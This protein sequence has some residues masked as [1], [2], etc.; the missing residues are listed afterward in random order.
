M[1]NF[2]LI[3]NAKKIVY[4]LSH[5]VYMATKIKII[6]SATFAIKLL[7]TIQGFCLKFKNITLKEIF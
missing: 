4:L 6:L 1:Q 3:I 7:N 5:R 2:Y